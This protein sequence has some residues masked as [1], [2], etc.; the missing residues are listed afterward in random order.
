LLQSFSF[1]GSGSP[2]TG[3][4]PAR[5][6]GGTRANTFVPE[7][8]TPE[9]IMTAPP[10]PVNINRGSSL[11]LPASAVA[12]TV[13]DVATTPPTEKVTVPIR[14]NHGEIGIGEVGPMLEQVLPL[15]EKGSEQLQPLFGANGTYLVQDFMRALEW[16]Y[17]WETSTSQKKSMG[18]V[19]RRLQQQ[20]QQQVEYQPRIVMDLSGE[21]IGAEQ[22]NLRVAMA[23]IAVLLGTAWHAGFHTGM[24]DEPNHNATDTDNP[25][26]GQDGLNYR[27]PFDGFA[28]EGFGCFKNDH[29]WLTGT[30]TG[31]AVQPNIDWII[32]DAK[33]EDRKL[34]CGLQADI[35]SRD[36]CWWGRGMLQMRHQCDYGDYQAHWGGLSVPAERPAVNLCNNPGQVCSDD[37]PELRFLTGL[38]TWVRDVIH[39]EDP[40]FDFIAELKQWVNGNMDMRSN[41]NFVDRVGGVLMYGDPNLLPPNYRERRSTVEAALD[42]IMSLAPV[43][44]FPTYG[45]IAKCKPTTMSSICKS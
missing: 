20:Q 38:Y 44:D 4:V 32:S 21:R 23:H 27:Y 10:K 40:T 41:G 6:S 2:N 1:P 36:C 15:L 28:E 19:D 9:P 22:G 39:A 5:S 34:I 33:E 43:L 30:P 14:A 3:S 24:C 29:E 16:S 26:C 25:G 12:A 7:A 35:H 45:N 18:I 37:Y 8:E 31:C 13:T 17:D 11:D 42:S